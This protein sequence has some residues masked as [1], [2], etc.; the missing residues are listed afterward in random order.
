MNFSWILRAWHISY[1]LI[2]SACVRLTVSDE[3]HSM[4]QGDDGSRMAVYRSHT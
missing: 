1:L 2:A 4:S 3:V